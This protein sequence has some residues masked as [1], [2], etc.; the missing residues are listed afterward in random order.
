MSFPSSS[1]VERDTV[2]VLVG[3]ST[4]SLGAIVANAS[5]GLH[6]FEI[7]HLLQFLLQLIVR[8][9]AALDYNSANLAD[10]NHQ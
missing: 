9:N 6:H 1:V 3:G 10:K 7:Q 5:K 2:N 8:A 4:P